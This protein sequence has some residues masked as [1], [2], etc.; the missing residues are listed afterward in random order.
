MNSTYA[1]VRSSDVFPHIQ[2][3]VSVPETLNYK[4]R[5]LLLEALFDVTFSKNSFTFSSLLYSLLLTFA[6]SSVA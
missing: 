3:S 2:D 5:L 4:T 6:Q 1:E